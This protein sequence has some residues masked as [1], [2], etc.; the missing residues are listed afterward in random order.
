MRLKNT[1]CLF[2][3]KPDNALWAI[4]VGQQIFTGVAPKGESVRDRANAEA[5]PHIAYTPATAAELV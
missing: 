4:P 3:A 1:I 5:D 2:K